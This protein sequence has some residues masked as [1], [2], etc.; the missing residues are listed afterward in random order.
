MSFLGRAAERVAR[1]GIGQAFCIQELKQAVSLVDSHLIGA[2][3]GRTA[4]RMQV[5]TEGGLSSA[6]GSTTGWRQ[7]N[8]HE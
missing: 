2:F 8:I 1:L 7:V 6:Y 5:V 3:Q 4:M